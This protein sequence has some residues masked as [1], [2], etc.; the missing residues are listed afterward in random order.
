[1]TPSPT[2]PP[3]GSPLPWSKRSTGTDCLIIDA[4][5]KRVAAWV[6]HEDA[7][8]IVAAVNTRADSARLVEELKQKLSALVKVADR[9]SRF[10][11]EMGSQ[12]WSQ[13]LEATAEAH[14]IIA[15]AKEQMPKPQAAE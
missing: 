2:T 15:R 12:E 10:A 8:E 3:R 11:E 1:M 5:N 7:D 4:K 13:Y 9:C 14:A 6:S